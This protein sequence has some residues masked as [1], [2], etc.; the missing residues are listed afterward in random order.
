MS[1]PT[2]GPAKK[3]AKKNATV[4]PGADVAIGTEFIFICTIGESS[5]Q[6]SKVLENTITLMMKHLDDEQTQCLCCEQV[7]D[8]KYLNAGMPRSL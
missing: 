8:R 5:S 4:Y 1:L 3:K 2:A 7:L 6:Y